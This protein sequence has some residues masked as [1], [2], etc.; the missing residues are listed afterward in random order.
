MRALGRSFFGSVAARLGRPS[1]QYLYIS[2]QIARPT[3][4]GIE[5]DNAQNAWL[6]P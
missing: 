4:V 2:R 6:P 3:L 1:G 5:G